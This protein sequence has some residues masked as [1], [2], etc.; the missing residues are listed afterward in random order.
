M[1]QRFIFLFQTLKLVFFE[2]FI[3]CVA[4]IWCCPVLGVG[5][6][7]RTVSATTPQLIHTDSQLHH[8]GGL[9]NHFHTFSI[10]FIFIAYIHTF[11]LQVS[12]QFI[13]I[14][15]K[16]Q[17]NRYF[18]FSQ[19]STLPTGDVKEKAAELRN[20]KS[21]TRRKTFKLNFPEEKSE[22]R[23]NFGTKIEQNYEHGYFSRTTVNHST[24]TPK[25]YICT[26]YKFS[27]K[28]GWFCKIECFPKLLPQPANI[29]T[30]IYSSY[31][32]HFATLKSRWEDDWVKAI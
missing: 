6:L 32:W 24:N 12:F 4:G 29:F 20:V 8:F 14:N 19:F 26:L 16:T 5:Q 25:S 22:N 13:L 28:R 17:W 7:I 11:P 31:R 2:F 23:D 10:A 27:Q 18:I 30:R 15:D 1:L 9:F 3:L 21:F